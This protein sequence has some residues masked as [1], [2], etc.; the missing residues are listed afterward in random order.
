MNDFGVI[1]WNC[2]NYIKMISFYYFVFVD[3]RDFV[4]IKGVTWLNIQL[5]SL[6]PLQDP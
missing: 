5:K 3:V 2:K 4:Q 6:E 1:R